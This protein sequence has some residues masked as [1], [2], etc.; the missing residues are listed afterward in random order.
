M[1]GSQR[2]LVTEDEPVI[3]A[4][5]NFVSLLSHRP[6]ETTREAWM[7]ILEPIWDIHPNHPECVLRAG[8]GNAGVRVTIG[9]IAATTGDATGDENIPLYVLQAL[10]D[11]TEYQLGVYTAGAVAL[12]IRTL[13]SPPTRFTASQLV[14]FLAQ[15][16]ILHGVPC[17][18]LEHASPERVAVG[19]QC[20]APF[21][22]RLPFRQV[23]H[24]ASLVDYAVYEA[25]RDRLLHSDRGRAALG[26]GGI[27]WR[28]A[29][30]VLSEDVFLQGP[31]QHATRVGSITGESYVD[32]QLTD[33]EVDQICGVYRT[34]ASE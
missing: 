4:I 24:S 31:S 1:F 32:D 12:L 13:P 14:T 10:G 26:M 17:S 8:A 2:S 30:E 15:A 11:A 7:T 34:W 20:Y 27:V 16:C 19:V 25:A 5:T 22:S 3:D 6:T 28:L 23:Q 33:V 29:Y 9:S 21:L 18:L